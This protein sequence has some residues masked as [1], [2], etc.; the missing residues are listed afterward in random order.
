[1]IEGVAAQGG[2]NRGMARKIL[3]WASC[4]FRPLGIDELLVALGDEFHSGNTR[5][6]E[7]AISHV[8]GNFVVVQNSKVALIHQTARS[9]LFE[10]RSQMSISIDRHESHGYIAMVCM[11]LLSNGPKWK[12]KFSQAQDSILNSGQRSPPQITL[13]E[14][15]LWY[16]TTHL[17]YHVSCASADP[18]E[19]TN[20]QM[21][22]F[23]FLDK[24]ALLWIN[25]VA[26]EGNL[27]ILTRS[28]AYLKAWAKRRTRNASDLSPT[29]LSLTLRSNGVEEMLRWANDIIRVV[30]RFGTYLV[31]NPSSILK[32]V[33]PFC[34]H[35]SMLYTTFQHHNNTL[36]VKGISSGKWDDCLAKLIME[37]DEPASKII[38]RDNYFITLLGANGVV[39]VWHAETCEEARRLRH[40]EYVTGLNAS[41]TASLV[42]TAGT[43]TIQ[44]WDVTSGERIHSV[45]KT[46][47][48]KLM[49]MAFVSNDTELL[50]AYDD[51]TILCVDLKSGK[52][53]WQFRAEE[54]SDPEH[55][56]PRLMSF[57]QDARKIAIA[58]RGRPVFV[59]KIKKPGDVWDAPE[60]VLWQPES[61][62]ALILYQ[63]MTLVDWDLESGL[64][65]Q[66]DH[67]KAR[68]MVLSSD[69]NL[70]LTSDNNG[71]LSVW[72]TGQFR[73]VYE[74]V[75]NEFVRDIAFSPDAQRLPDDSNREDT[76][77]HDSNVCSIPV[78]SSDDNTRVQI[79]ALI[80]GKHDDYFCTGKDDGTV[81]ILDMF[82][83][84]QHRK[85]YAH[86]TAGSVI[87]MAWS[88]NRRYF[89]SVDDSGRLI[90]KRLE[91]PL[92]PQAK[93]KVFPLIDVRLG[94]AIAQLMF[95]TSEEFLLV[96]SSNLDRV[97][98]TKTKE[99]LVQV[100][101]PNEAA[102]RWVMHPFDTHLLVCIK[103]NTHTICQWNNLEPVHKYGLAAGG[104]FEN[105]QPGL[106]ALHIRETYPQ[107]ELPTLLPLNADDLYR[108]Y[109]LTVSSF[110]ILS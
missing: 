71:T 62:N 103:R 31:Q 106:E 70:L 76:S 14:P 81:N 100:S 61:P 16:A 11:Q 65:I 28:A 55:S 52:E 108:E 73:L 25:A 19:A 79:S 88:S 57:G 86:S 60:V 17:A 27:R 67:L 2:R 39:I 107:H 64:Q 7:L 34:P 48:G 91:K 44:V 32:H 69:G 56:R 94:F 26:L 15:F 38:A 46:N 13:S 87:E 53:K 95:S 41:K 77:A 21:A 75:R 12:E 50:I 78:V 35:D 66:H 5:S 22:V 6:L 18:E 102:R 109:T 80:C 47:Q 54:P 3:T 97:Y 33:V 82:N 36:S 42:A 59:W 63:D 68:E 43:K 8:C 92:S 40:G 20:L 83:S 58:Y 89:A 24:Y 84:T 23:E 101:R 110:L 30:G 29:S 105:N 74:L 45:N 104:R 85:L 1:M 96:S 72:T 90:A 98:S 99:K 4:A 51:C 10:E 93:W 9:F 49:S 37:G